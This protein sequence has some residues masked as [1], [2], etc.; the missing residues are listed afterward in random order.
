MN[1]RL[2]YTFK[3]RVKFSHLPWTPFA[4]NIFISS[5]ESDFVFQIGDSFRFSNPWL[6]FIN[7][8]SR[9]SNKTVNWPDG[10]SLKKVSSSGVRLFRAIS[11]YYEVPTTSLQ[12]CV[13][14]HGLNACTL[15][16]QWKSPGRTCTRC[17]DLKLYIMS[18]WTTIATYQMLKAWNPLEC[19][20]N[21][22]ENWIWAIPK[23]HGGLDVAVFLFVTLKYN[24]GTC[25]A[26]WA[27]KN[28]VISDIQVPSLVHY[29]LNLLKILTLPSSKST[30][31][32]PFKEKR[33][34]EVVRIDSKII[35]HMRVS[36]EKPSSSFCVMWDF[37]WGCSRNLKLIRTLVYPASWIW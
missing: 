19:W 1:E 5:C 9:K 34:S 25:H 11:S 23:V 21:S 6:T 15:R 8:L 18:T 4:F 13:T 30:S 2:G 35:F 33:I 7:P 12:P 26:G 32:Q 36:Y 31:S 10:T 20:T 27:I 3:E 22:P 14:C 16:A 17:L 37:W 29:L 24:C 28:L